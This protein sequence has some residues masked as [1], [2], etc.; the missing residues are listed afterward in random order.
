MNRNLP[1]YGVPGEIKE[2]LTTKKDLQTG[3]SRLP[4]QS[5]LIEDEEDY[6]PIKIIQTS[7]AF[8]KNDSLEIE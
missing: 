4:P 8:I 5:Y 6:V 2:F 7:P 3:N 1:I